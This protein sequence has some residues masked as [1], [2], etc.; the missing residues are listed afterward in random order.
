MHE[1]ANPED[2]KPFDT[3]EGEFLPFTA[4]CIGEEV[5]QEVSDCLRSGW[6]AT[7]PRVQQFETNLQTYIEAPHAIAVN[8]ATPGLHLALLACGIGPGDEVITTPM[9]F[10][11]TTNSIVHTGAKPVFVDI[12]RDTYNMDVSKIEQAITPQTKAILP[13]HYAGLPVDLDA[14]YALAQ[15]HTLR[16]IEDAAHVIGC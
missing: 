10:V 13:V 3:T 15:K 9:T 6:L 4:P 5:I 11:S 2:V 7:G 16:V 14:L 1:A 12:D 8:A